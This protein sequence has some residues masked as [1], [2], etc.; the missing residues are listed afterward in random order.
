MTKF[1]TPYTERDD[2][3]KTGITF[4]EPSRTQQ[5]F[6][7]EC[8]V[9]VLVEKALKT[10][11]YSAFQAPNWDDVDYS[12]VGEYADALNFVNSVNT[13]FAELPAALRARF[14]NNI[15]DYAD[16]VADPANMQEC[17]RLGLLQGP[18][19]AQNFNFGPGSGQPAV[20]NDVEVQTETGTVST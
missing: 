11:D 3:Q 18:E 4:T 12:E 13:D 2:A 8:D 16:F 19:T 5:Q 10:G 6:A 7:E 9:N 17:I 1:R 20:A 15:S 14:N